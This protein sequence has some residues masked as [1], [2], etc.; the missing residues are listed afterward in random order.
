MDSV[1]LWLLIVAA[2]SLA[3]AGL[4][5]PIGARARLAALGAARWLAPVLAVTLVLYGLQT[6]YTGY[7]SDAVENVGFFFVPF[8]ALFVLLAGAR[9]DRELLR[10]LIVVV[11]LAALLVAVVAFGQYV[12]GKVF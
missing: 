2:M 5:A 4:A 12:T 3:A 7:L 10:A 6:G 1:G 9:W 11:G 8:A